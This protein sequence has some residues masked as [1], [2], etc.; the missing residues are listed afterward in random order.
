MNL[1]DLKKY[2][3]VSGTMFTVRYIVERE[4][5]FGILHLTKVES[6]DG[7]R[8]TLEDLIKMLIEKAD[9]K[10]KKTATIAS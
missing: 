10:V 3:E 2:T 7:Y 4:E 9:K 5:W 6:V 8:G 1:E